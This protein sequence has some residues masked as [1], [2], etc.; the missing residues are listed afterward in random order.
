MDI[1]SRFNRKQIDDRKIDALIGLSKGIV[2]DGIVNQQEAEMLQN[3]LVQSRQATSNPIIENLLEKVDSILEDGVLDDE[4]SS[5]LMSV[6]QQIGGENSEIGE[7]AKTSKLPVDDP[8]PSIIFKNSTFLFTGTC[9]FGSRKQCQDVI[10]RLGGKNAKSV[11]KS[12]NYLVL[13]TYITDSWAHE[14]FGRKIEKAIEYRDNNVPLS[15]VTEEHW[16]N[17]GGLL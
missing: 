7:L 3:W 8:M 1:F 4:E 5:E 17:C 13:G 10:E 16:A 2:A 6:L 9:A 11:T 15:I 12:L 14:T